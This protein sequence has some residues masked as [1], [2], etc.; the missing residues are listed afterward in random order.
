MNWSVTRH[1]QFA[2]PSFIS[3][4]HQ[5]ATLCTASCRMMVLKLWSFFYRTELLVHAFIMS[6]GLLKSSYNR[7]YLNDICTGRKILRD[8]HAKCHI[9]LLISGL[10]NGRMDCCMLYWFYIILLY[11]WVTQ[12]PST[13]CYINAMVAGY[14]RNLS[15]PHKSDNTIFHEESCKKSKTE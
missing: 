4:I 8:L 9:A 14:L 11:N 6:L 12:F 10:L 3:N 15:R 1:F 7:L 2:D 5:R 13:I